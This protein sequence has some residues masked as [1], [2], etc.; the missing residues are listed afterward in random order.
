[1]ELKDYST[2]ELRTELKRRNTEEK[3]MRIV[4]GQQTFLV[5]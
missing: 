3:E 1:M 5:I 2:E 4:I